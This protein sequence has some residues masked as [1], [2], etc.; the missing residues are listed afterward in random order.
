VEKKKVDAII[1]LRKNV[2]AIIEYKKPSEFNTKEKQD[3]A[4]NQEI[5]VARKLDCKLIIATDT[6]ETIW[7]NALTSKRIKDENN[8][9]LNINFDPKEEKMVALIEKINYSINELNSAIKPKQLV[10]PTDLAKQIWQDIWSVSG[11]TP[12]NCLYTFVELFI[13]KYLSDLGVLQG[14]FSF[15]SLANNFEINTPDELLETYAN[16]IR[17]KIKDL[18]PANPADNTTIINGTIFVSKD[19]K[20]ITGY[21]TVFKKILQ[22]F[23]DYGKLEN[24]D[25]D[26]KSQLFE[27][28]LKESISKKNWGQ[29]FTPLKVVRAIVE[30]VKDEIKDGIKIC[31]PACGVGKF[32]LEPLVTRLNYLYDI[33][34][35]GI[36]PKISIYGFDKG[37]D[38]DEQK[39]IILAKANM[40]IYFSDLIKENA[41]LTK[42]FAKLFNDSF[43]LK[44]NSILGTLSDAVKNEYDLILTN[45]PYVT[46]RSSNLKDEIKKDGELVNY[47]K[48]NALGVEGLFMEWIIKALK[49]NG[50]AFVVIPENML[51]R[52]SDANL[53][54]FILEYCT[55]DGIISLPKKTFFSTVQQTSIL[56]ITKKTNR[57]EQQIRP[58]FTYLVSEIGES[59]DV[60]RFHI[61]QNDLNEAVELF[62]GFK[63]SVDYFVKNNSD[64]RCK[65]ISIEWFQNS[66]ESSWSIE[67]HWTKNEKIDLGI[68]DDAR[69][70]SASDYKSAI[71]ETLDNIEGLKMELDNLSP[72]PDNISYISQPLH[73]LFSFKSGNSKITQAYIDKH[74][75]KHVVYSSNTK[76]DGIFGYID[77]YDFDEECIQIT[78]NGVYAGTVFYREKHKFSINGDARL[79]IKKDDNLN[80]GYLLYELKKVFEES[81]FNWENKPTVSKTKDIL[82][83]IPVNNDGSF[84]KLLQELLFS[85]FSKM[86][87]ISMSINRELEKLKK[88]KFGL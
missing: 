75:G 88:I 14:A 6:T 21:S 58:V 11:A 69:V 27:S 45:P 39:T 17:P 2:I 83:K 64:K 60:N 49:P 5:E 57:T 86:D 46:S 13:F 78:T 44:T 70:V 82:I 81:N 10:N 68:T 55:I 76:N 3:K 73:E 25:Y 26:F 61:E 34:K 72:I 62:R 53:R 36:T 67:R 74:K 54:K 12:E 8:K 85:N 51:F 35:N 23:K 32:L 28:F 47:Y 7:V 66:V 50:K 24:I 31:D 65:V 63:G 4:I 22:K 52:P 37:F 20:A 59:R 1:V 43:T 33:N 71:Q 41:G 87:F 15:Y 79:L 56:C 38:K 84:S 40:L 30:M 16:S 19:Q 80:Y 9:E 29:F 77:N 42:D 48:I 18:F